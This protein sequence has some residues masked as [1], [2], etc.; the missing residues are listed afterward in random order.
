MRTSAAH[1]GV[2]TS[3]EPSHLSE[4][5]RLEDFILRQM[6]RIYRSTDRSV[7]RYRRRMTALAGEY[8]GHELI[9]RGV[10]QPTG[11]GAHGMR[12]EEES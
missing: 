6:H 12:L 8:D 11:A 5:A 3:S 7:A 9:T 10:S 2:Q 1:R 4:V